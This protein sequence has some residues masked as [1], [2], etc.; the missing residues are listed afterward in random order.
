MIQINVGGIY[1][2][3]DAQRR[4]QITVQSDHEATVHLD[5][6]A[7]ELRLRGDAPVAQPHIHEIG[8]ILCWN[9]EIFEGL[10]IRPE[11]NDGIKLSSAMSRLE[12]T[13]AIV[14]LL[15]TLEGPY[16]F[17]Y[18][19]RQSKRLF[20][21]RDPLGRRSLLVHWP[22]REL[23][24]LLLASVAIGTNDGYH[25][26][27]LSTEHIYVLN[28]DSLG[29]QTTSF[30]VSLECLSR[31]APSGNTS[32][33]TERVNQA[34]PP[35]DTELPR[36]Q[37][38]DSIPQHLSSA[39]DG[40]IFHLDHSVALR[41]SNIPQRCLGSPSSSE[42]KPSA[43]SIP[44]RVA[45]LF[46]G[47]IDS[48]IC[49][50]LA[51][52]HIPPDEPI[53][54]LNIAFE[55]PRKIRVQVDGNV[56]G[57]NKKK[58]K[59][60][61]L[62]DATSTERQLSGR[63]DPDYLVPDRSAGLSELEELQR[64]CPGRQWNFV[65]IDVPFGEYQ[66]AQPTVRSIMWPCQTVMDLSLAMA[67]YFAARGVGKVRSSPTTHPE[68]YTST[69]RVLLN[70]LGSDELLGGYG[71]HRTAYSAGGWPAV[72]DELQLEM[73]RIPTRNL[74]RD[75]RV[76]SA[77]GKE[78]R[79]PFLSL[80]VVNYLVGLPVHVKMD[81]RLEV[82]VGDKMLLRLAARKMGLVEASTRKKRAMQFGSHAARMEVGVAD[83]GGILP[84]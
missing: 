49:A 83:G 73:D 50:F 3:P 52:K 7:S 14:Q 17:V 40:L 66:A 15:G 53:D 82:G 41:V 29:G 32:A 68:P 78:A 67:L 22:S 34:L 45:V 35:I 44:T 63:Y 24:Y 9:G 21:A 10:D 36:L 54:L 64:L 60:R 31:L 61:A 74:G 47:G 55:N 43:R 13:S 59:S 80:D 33:R 18:Y 69:A 51:H 57:I 37:S 12:G 76:I 70:G 38:L 4:Y 84:V 56:G 6:F 81:P 75:D 1:A 48:T 58:Q 25:L 26:T 72:I 28:I 23:P 39:V 42:E 19:H 79:H 30:G 20:F 2:G 46:S 16:A 5:F 11:E 27:E 77:H 62:Q 65:E 8:D 71:R